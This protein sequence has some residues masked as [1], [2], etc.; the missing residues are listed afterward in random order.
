MN[1]QP[2]DKCSKADTWAFPVSIPIV[3]QSTDILSKADTSAQ[4][5][6]NM[7]SLQP[8]DKC[9]KAETHRKDETSR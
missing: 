5:W 1:L 7:S 3:L 6:A 2:T 9:S 4:Y 8:T